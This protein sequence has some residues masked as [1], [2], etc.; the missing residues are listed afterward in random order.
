MRFADLDEWSLRDSVLHRRDARAKIG[1]ML[2]LLIAIGRGNIL[3][4]AACV[5]LALLL[6]RL[7]V[8]AL[9]LRASVVLP[10]SLSFAIA[11]VVS[12]RPEAAMWATVRSY[13]SAVCVLVLIGSTSLPA[14]LEGLR[15]L[16]APLFLLEV[17]QFVYRYLFLVAEQG[18]RM[19][20]AATA[21]GARRSFSAVSNSVGVLFARSY[22]RA[23]A[24][25]RA[26]LARGYDGW[27]PTRA[28]NQ[29]AMGDALMLSIACAGTV[30]SFR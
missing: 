6:A 1:A 24:I 27:L 3:Y 17:I 25:H 11:S 4:P 15:R 23:D 16:G 18:R 9:L 8:P 10:F 29:F 7:P 14:I 21:R 30:A 19:A 22:D 12:D 26:M 5:T 28:T 2:V 13:L 20:I